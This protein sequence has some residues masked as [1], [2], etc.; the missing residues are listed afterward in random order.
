MTQIQPVIR[1][2]NRADFDQTL[3]DVWAVVGSFPTVPDCLVLSLPMQTA[4][5]MAKRVLGDA[6][7][8][9]DERMVLDC[10]GELANVLAGQAKSLLANSSHHFSFSLPKVMLMAPDSH[11]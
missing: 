6:G 5:G 4:H 1:E 10:I 8:P 3:G 11:V 2:V 7:E 9:M